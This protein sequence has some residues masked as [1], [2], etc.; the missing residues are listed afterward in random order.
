MSKA[1]Q[2]V[3]LCEDRLQEVFVCHFLKQ[4][5]GKKNRDIRVVPYPHGGS[6]GAGE[7]HV[8]DKYPDQLRAY[9]ARSA[10][11]KTI[12][13]AVID[14]DTGTV[15]EHNG[16]L[17]EACNAAQP[18]IV[19]VRQTDEAVVHVIPKRHIETWLAYLDTGSV[20]EDRRYKP[21]YTFKGRESD[22]H[23]LVDKLAM[24]CKDR[25]RLTGM[26]DSLTQACA[27]FERIR[28]LL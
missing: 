3:V 22:C 24:A 1:S 17:D 4:G 21:H 14:A 13:I 6:G 28:G 23:R 18:S 25:N 5:W 2:I 26:P 27:E 16:E 8:R 15:Q 19:G 10:R 9:R 7:K 20:D 11:A 12:L